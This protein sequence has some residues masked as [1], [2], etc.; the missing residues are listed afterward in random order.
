MKCINCGED[1]KKSDKFC[2][3]CGERTSINKEDV[4]VRTYIGEGYEKIKDESFSLPAF[5]LGPLYMFYRKLYA[6]GV[7]SILLILLVLNLDIMTEESIIIAYLT[8]DVLFGIFFNKIY[9]SEV[10]K[11]INI[12]KNNNTE[13]KE[14]ELIRICK[15]Q[16]RTT[17]IVPIIYVL[18]II[19]GVGLL[20]LFDYAYYI[21]P[22]ATLYYLTENE[23]EYIETPE[24]EEGTIDCYSKEEKIEHKEETKEDVGCSS[25]DGIEET[26]CIDS[27]SIEP[28][29]DEPINKSDGS[30]RIVIQEDGE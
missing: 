19:L 25:I 17:I 24:M 6:Y 18:T 9:M 15:N 7:L 12:I 26:D 1:I 10:K 22:V 8:F 27:E 11:R 16:G 4:L 3:K 30:D 29:D 23:D 14:E 28:V 5:L 2:P 21:E 13:A 20:L